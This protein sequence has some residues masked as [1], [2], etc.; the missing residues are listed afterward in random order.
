MQVDNWERKVKS[1]SETEIN[2][3]VKVPIVGSSKSCWYGECS[4]GNLMSDA[5]RWYLEKTR[6]LKQSWKDTVAATLWHG[7][8]MTG[9][10]IG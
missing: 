5:A 10:I 6:Y 1:D 4:G 3:Y 9:T 8:A 2:S 7:G